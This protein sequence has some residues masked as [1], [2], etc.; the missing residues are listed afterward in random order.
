MEQFVLRLAVAQQQRGHDVQVMALQ[1]GPLI[2]VADARTLRL[3]ILERFGSPL[4]FLHGLSVIANVNPDILHVHNPTSL[5]YA[6]AGKLLTRGSLVLTDHGQ[7]AG[8]VRM[9]RPWELRE[10][11]AIVSVSAETERGHKDAIQHSRKVLIRN[12]VS[13]RQPSRARDEVRATLNLLPGMTA[14]IVAR[15]EPIKDHKTLLAAY[16]ILQREGFE[17]NLII[18][19]DGSE[20]AALQALATELG[21]N[22]HRIRFLGY[23]DDIPDL[24]AA[25]DMFVLS[26]IMEGLPLAMLEAMSQ[27]LPVVATDVGGNAELIT[28]GE[29]GFLVPSQNPRAL[30][31]AI[32]RLS[33]DPSLTRRI[34]AAAKSRVEAEFSFEGMVARYEDLYTALHSG[35]GVRARN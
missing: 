33:D 6:A 26:S 5:H 23:R 20:K 8:I 13:L 14:I 12:G 31:D 4:R 18:V 27:G 30:A 19:G 24:L 35:V 16:A 9:P 22:P 29:T 32:V 3:H 25:C 11:D 17:P 15:L 1:S 7:C 21:L 28:E 34:S 10:T 2:E